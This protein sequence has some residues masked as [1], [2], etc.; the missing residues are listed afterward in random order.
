MSQANIIFHSNLLVTFSWNIWLAFHLIQRVNRLFFLPELS[1]SSVASEM[2]QHTLNLRYFFSTKA[3]LHINVW[4]CG[5]GSHFKAQ[6]CDS[7]WRDCCILTWIYRSDNFVGVGK[8][9]HLCEWLQHTLYLRAA[10]LQ[11]TLPPTLTHTTLSSGHPSLSSADACCCMHGGCS[12][13][14]GA[15]TYQCTLPCFNTE[16]MNGLHAIRLKEEDST[17]GGGDGGGCAVCEPVVAG[18]APWAPQTV[19]H[20]TQ[21]SKFMWQGA[22]ATQ[23]HADTWP[24]VSFKWLNVHT[25]TVHEA[26][27]AS[28]APS[29]LWIM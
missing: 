20:H 16:Q 18:T 1:S 10:A 24:G 28:A 27:D 25:A 5:W 19:P 23:Q 7:N 17:A 4:M 29:R 3:N 21:R 6:V 2:H 12:E 8:H 15:V 9:A 11:P 13:D 26:K 14:G 22:A